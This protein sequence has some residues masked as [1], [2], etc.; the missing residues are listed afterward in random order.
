MEKLARKNKKKNLICLVEV[1]LYT[2]VLFCAFAVNIKP[3]MLVH[4]ASD[5]FG[6]WTAAANFLGWSWVDSASHNAYYSFGYGIVLAPIL[7][8]FKDPST[9]YTVAILINI[10]FLLIGFYLLISLFSKIY[11]DVS[12]HLIILVSFVAT[13]FSGNFFYSMMTMTECFLWVLFL[14]ATNWL[15]DY[16]VRDQR[17]K[18]V[19]L[20]GLASFLFMV[21]MRS[22]VIGIAI[23][24]VLFLSVLTNKK[25]R[26]KEVICLCIFAAIWLCGLYG[27][28]LVKRWLMARQYT[29]STNDANGIGSS[30]SK[31]N[32]IFSLNGL[33]S[34]IETVLGRFYYH[35]ATTLLTFFTGM[36]IV[37]VKV[38]EFFKSK[39]YQ[40]MYF[41]SFVFLSTLASIAI[42]AISMINLQG[43]RIDVL[44]YG[45]YSDYVMSLT[46]IVSVVEMFIKK[47]IRVPVDIFVKIQLLLSVAVMCWVRVRKLN[48]LLD[49]SIPSMFCFFSKSEYNY[50]QYLIVGIGYTLVSILLY[51]ILKKCNNVKVLVAVLIVIGIGWGIIGSR[52]LRVSDT[53]NHDEE[54]Y[55]VYRT[56]NM[57]FSSDDEEIYYCYTNRDQ[58]INWYTF[59]GVDRM[60]VCIR[61]HS[62][63]YVNIENYDSIPDGAIIITRGDAS[64]NYMIDDPQLL[65]NV[66]FNLYRKM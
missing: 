46:F 45:R 5:E 15:Y 28:V 17:Y 47:K 49:M 38:V 6:Y 51:I 53:H 21:H 7:Y 26:K 54:Y 18:I 57:N 10:I 20:A 59:L 1:L 44:F 29:F 31:V 62:I 27:T 64:V 8:F 34:L 4:L 36:Y 61:N 50:L 63:K 3:T 24:F 43:N 39:K 35:G 14:L 37:C 19:L 52:S 60:Q 56:L 13:L 40:Q 55:Q 48:V 2:V 9:M 23:G 42:S 22:V 33:L 16:F 65:S 58:E 41:W 66:Q 12:K 32:N 25:T 30:I 11:K